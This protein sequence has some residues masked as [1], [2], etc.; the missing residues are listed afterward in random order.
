MQTPGNRINLKIKNWYGYTRSLG[1]ILLYLN[2]FAKPYALLGLKTTENIESILVSYQNS[3]VA[4]QKAAQ[5]IFGA[6]SL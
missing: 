4:Q 2:V 6:Y 3:A 5:L 1:P